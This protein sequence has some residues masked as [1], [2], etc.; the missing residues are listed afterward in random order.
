MFLDY[1]IDGVRYRDKLDM[2]IVPG[3]STLIKK[4]N[5]QTMR[6]AQAAKAKKILDIQ[7]GNVN[8]RKSN[9][10]DVL[11]QEFILQQSQDYISRGHQ[12]YGMTLEKIANWVKRFG[13]RASLRTVDKKWLMD[14]VAYMNKHGMAE[15]TVYMYFSNLNTIFNRAYRAGIINENPISRMDKTERPQRPDI[16]REY[17]TLEEVQQLMNTPCGNDSVKRAFLFACFTGLRLSDIEALTWENIKPTTDGGWQIEQ[18]QK[19]TKKIVTIPLSD[20]ALA[21]LPERDSNKGIVW[22]KLPIRQELGKYLKKW[23]AAAGI[24]KHITYHCSRHTNATLLLTFGADIYTVSA[25]L[26]HHDIATTQIYAKVV[27]QKKQEAV[28]LIPKIG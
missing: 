9:E 4:K 23:V 14:F 15:S 22:R 3:N 25:L 19:K 17:L 18:K 24:E 28:N 11:L 27:N 10:P 21:Q 12:S 2:Y 5:E 6:V 26:G 8:L 16:E 1:T 20:N 13:R 7:N